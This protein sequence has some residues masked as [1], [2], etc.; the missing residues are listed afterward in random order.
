M[1][2]AANRFDVAIVGGGHNAL[3][4]AALLARAGRSVV[5]CEALG[6]FGGGAAAATLMP[7]IRAPQCAHTVAGFPRALV[8]TLGL[9]R[10]GLRVLQPHM[11]RLALDPDGRHIPL[12]GPRRRDA[13]ATREAIFHWSRGDA[14]A[15]PGFVKLLDAGSGFLAPLTARPPLPFGAAA[16]RRA[17]LAWAV[18]LL[19]ARRQGKARM[20]ELLRLLPSNAADAIE[21]E[22]RTP[23]LGGALAFDAVLGG[24]RGPRAPGTMLAWL[25]SRAL[26][27]DGVMQIAGGPAALI[28]ALHASAVARGAEIRTRARVAQIKIRDGR[29]CGLVLANGD[30]IDA[31]AV[32]STADARTT[33]L[34]LVGAAHLD[35]GLVRDL[36][37]IRRAPLGAKVNLALSRLPAFAQASEEDLKGRLVVAPS[38][39]DVERAA[40]PVKYGGISDHP[41][42][43]VTIPTLT[44]ETLAPQGRHVMSVLVPFVP[45]ALAQGWETGGQE[46]VARVIRTLAV[47]APDLPECVM[48]GEVLTPPDIT[49]HC[50]IADADWHH[51]ELALDQI[52]AMRPL[53]Q[54][55]TGPDGPAA[56]VRGLY[57]GGAAAHPGG[58]LNGRAGQ[59]AAAAVLRALRRAGRG[60]RP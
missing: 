19:R 47:Y 57:L 60:R 35:A 23:L 15:W 55:A 28:E 12:D 40:D 5:V 14:Q 39:Q 9:R 33:Y 21:D 24:W 34:D 51:G 13:A 50:G 16:G 36:G 53:P 20:G 10:H 44:D 37:C 4:A 38:V 6:R 49:I 22:F 43:E 41:V 30:E 31:E 32:I 3:V 56:P 54:L 7:G 59:L 2:G 52:L 42:M 17:Q 8:R 58:G 18:Q 29:A 46:L 11:P 26:A 27:R 1:S 25:W 45:M 48:A